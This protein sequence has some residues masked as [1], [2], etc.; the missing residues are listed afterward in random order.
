MG[1]LRNE[2]AAQ[3]ADEAEQKMFVICYRKDAQ[4]VKND[5]WLS[6]NMERVWDEGPPTGERL[7]RGE[8]MGK[9]K[10][11]EPKKLTMPVGMIGN[12]TKMG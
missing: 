12:E 10:I 6:R 7:D 5:W 4:C 8:G 1:V 2:L 3:E 9:S 11:S